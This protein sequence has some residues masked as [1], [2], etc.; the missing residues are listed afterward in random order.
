MLKLVTLELSF[1]CPNGHG[2]IVQL[3][4]QQ[5]PNGMKDVDAWDVSLHC[6]QCKWEGMQKGHQRTGIRLVE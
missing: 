1:S 5:S 3:P 4:H 2:V 6:P